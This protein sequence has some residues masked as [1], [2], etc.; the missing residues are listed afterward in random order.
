MA[1]PT[2]WYDSSSDLTI[3][4]NELNIKDDNDDTLLNDY[5]KKANRRID[6]FVFAFLDTVPTVTISEITD[7]LKQAAILDVSRRYEVRLKSF[8]AAKEY[9]QDF[10]DILESIR[11]R[12]KAVPTSRN[13]LV[14]VSTSYDTGDDVLFSQ[15]IFR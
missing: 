13:K 12:A 3:V 2:L 15:R 14:A 8:E 11:I 5:G 4:K 9:K 7:D 6:N 10:D 1:S